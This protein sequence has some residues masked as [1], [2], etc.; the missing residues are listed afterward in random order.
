[1]DHFRIFSCITYAYVPYEKRRK[2][3]D[4]GEKCAFLGVS[5]TSKAYKLFNPLIEKL[6]TNR[7]IVFDEK[8]TWDW[9]R[10]QSTQVPYDNDVEEIVSM[11][12][13]FIKCYSN[14]R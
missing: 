10:Q 7:D 14:S 9:N 13:N 12:K 1:M 5:E 3:D 11:P 8:C 4:K 2:L 6:V